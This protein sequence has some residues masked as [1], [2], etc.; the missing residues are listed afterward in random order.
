MAGHSDCH[1]QSLASDNYTL[2]PGHVTGSP[3]DPMRAGCVT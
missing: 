2:R 1:P 3:P